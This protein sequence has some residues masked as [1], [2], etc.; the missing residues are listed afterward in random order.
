MAECILGL[1][2][3]FLLVATY[4]TGYMIGNIEGEEKGWNE[5]KQFFTEEL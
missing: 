3:T 1:I 4:M 5:A 2:F